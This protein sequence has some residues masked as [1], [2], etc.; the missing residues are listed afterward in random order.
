MNSTTE[1][2]ESAALIKPQSLK[3]MQHCGNLG[4][5]SHDDLCDA[6]VWLLQ[7]LVSQGLELPRVQWIEA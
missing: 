7:G 6:L 5:E 2:E 1:S 4:V 3:A